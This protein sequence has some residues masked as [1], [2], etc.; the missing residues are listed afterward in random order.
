MTRAQLLGI[1]GEDMERNIFRVPLAERKAEL[2]ELPWVAHATVM[3]LAAE[4]LRV[5]IMERT[6]VAFVRQGSRIG[7][8]D[9]NG[10]L[11][12]MPMDVKTGEHYS[13]PVVTGFGRRIRCR[14]GGADED[15]R[16]VYYGLDGAGEKISE[17][18]SEVDLSNPE[19]VRALIPDQGGEDDGALWRRQFPG[20]ISK[21]LKSI[22]R[23]GGRSIRI[24]P[25]S[26]CDTSGRWCWR[27]SRDDGSSAPAPSDSDWLPP[28]R[29]R[30]EDG[31]LRLRMNTVAGAHKLTRPLIRCEI[32]GQEA[33]SGH[34]AWN[35]IQGL[36]RSV[37]QSGCRQQTKKSAPN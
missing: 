2:E 14:A 22:C 10:V 21:S 31:C 8:V 30:Q 24:C 19:D 33:G 13:F 32:F 18:L 7:L 34:Q 9:G 20:S 4:R 6:P 28:L 12:D 17:K 23:S 35:C 36:Q 5:S 29:R 16:E 37:R 26:I 25:L 3:R 11:L 27:C 1:F 15:L